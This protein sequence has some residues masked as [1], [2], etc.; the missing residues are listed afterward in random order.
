[1]KP[2]AVCKSG[3]WISLFLVLAFGFT[4]YALSVPILSDQT[5]NDNI[6]DEVDMDSA[7]QADS[8][9][10]TTSDGIV[11]L[12]GTVDN[13]L[14][15]DRARR[16]AEAVKGVRAVINKISVVPTLLRTDSEI[17][18]NVE[19]ALLMDP[20]TEFFKVDVKVKDSAVT[21]SG[22]V[23]SFQEKWICEKVV[24]GVKGVK[25]V[26]N[27]LIVDSKETRTDRE[28]QVE[29]EEVLKW[30][31]LVNHVP[32]TVEVRD[33]TVYLSG[34]VGSAAEKRQ[35]RIDAYAAGVR[36]VDTTG[37]K[38]QN[39]ANDPKMRKR[40]YVKK[41]DAEIERA[42]KDALLYDP[43]VSSLNVS[44]EVSDGQ[45]TLRG[46]VGN[47]ESKPFLPE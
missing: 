23:D 16:I 20:V 5:I 22:T 28:I 4:P 37:L 29:V 14:A 47:Y 39:W 30:D 36:S 17:R 40:A 32:I 46:E 31:V 8:I 21:L 33:G 10:V 35:A 1:M 12:S 18:D 26:N 2:F 7:V 34:V 44:V 27:Q 3:V 24:K 42:V 6:Y 38:I 11:T 19:D 43:R 41:T 15:K 45:V 9:Y 13:L 25:E